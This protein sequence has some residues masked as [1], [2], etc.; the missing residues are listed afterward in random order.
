MM[1]DARHV[2]ALERTSLAGADH[3]RQG[4]Y[5]LDDTKHEGEDSSSWRSL[6]KHPDED[7]VQLDVDRSF[8][9]YPHGTCSCWI[10]GVSHITW[11]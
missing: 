8:I 10:L 6:P 7:Q 11:N 9:Y 4:P 1:L 5:Y 3:Q 2:R